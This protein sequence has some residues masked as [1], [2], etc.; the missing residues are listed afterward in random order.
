MRCQLLSVVLAVACARAVLAQDV[1]PS[2]SAVVPPAA[3]RAWFGRR[4][5]VRTGIGILAIG[6][7]SLA[8]EPM[9][10]AMRRPSVQ[11]SALLR[12]STKA[13]EYAGDPG[14][15]II[16]T[17]LYLAGKLSHRTEL[18]D[19]S[20]H[21]VMSLVVSSAL[22]QTLKLS[23]GRARPNIAQGDAYVF[24]PF[25]EPRTDYNALP[26]GHTTAVFAVAGAFSSELT[27]THPHAARIVRPMLYSVAALVGGSRMYNNRHWLSDVVAGATIG[28]VTAHRIVKMTH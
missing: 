25:R 22:T 28:E 15:L 3:K 9:A 16:S 1:A 5:A 12:H 2:S 18:S 21:A 20:K 4:D 6:A 14:A 8:D 11:S 23:V 13:V 27:R 26:S 24:H 7:L 17:G 19:A 10:K